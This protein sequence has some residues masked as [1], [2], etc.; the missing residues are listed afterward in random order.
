MAS[1]LVHPHSAAAISLQ[2]SSH[3]QVPV[4]P[5]AFLFFVSVTVFFPGLPRYVLST[6]S[7]CS[8]QATPGLVTHDSLDPFGQCSDIL[9]MEKVL[10]TTF[11]TCLAFGFCLA[12]ASVL[13]LLF[14]SLGVAC[15]DAGMPQGLFQEEGDNT[16]VYL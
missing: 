8:H 6:R 2:P 13:H 4:E 10:S 11:S 5:A 12:E 14:C 1:V 16:E 7:S 15:V 9:L 3:I